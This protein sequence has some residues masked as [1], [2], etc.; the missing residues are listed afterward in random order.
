VRTRYEFDHLLVDRAV[1]AG[2][3]FRQGVE[4]TAVLRHGPWVS[5]AVARTG[6]ANEEVRARF[7]VAADGASSRFAAQAGVARDATRPL[8]IA[9]RRYYRSPRPQQR[10]LEAFVNL[11]D[12]PTSGVMAGYGWIFPLGDGVVN[13][14][15]GLLNTFTRFNEV[16]AQKLFRQFVDALPPE[17]GFSED[18]ATGPLLS[19][20]I[21][22]AMNRRPLAVPGMLLVGD[23]GGLVNPFNGEGISEAVESGVVGAEVALAAVDGRGPRDLSEYERRLDALWGPYYRL[24]RTFVRLIGRPRVMRTLTGVGMRV[25]PVME[26]AFKLLANLYREEGGGFGDALARAMLRAASVLRVG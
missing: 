2:A 8:G 17:W 24:G 4:A 25:P 26:F 20:P 15:A 14:G 23:A 10:V 3:R 5:G 13:V 12:E 9:A 11:P 7:V 19:G 1:Q 16:S 18:T 21:P 22:M 6:G